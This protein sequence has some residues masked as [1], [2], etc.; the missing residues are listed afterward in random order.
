MS[1]AMDRLKLIAEIRQRPVLWDFQSIEHKSRE[2]A[3]EM[4]RDVAQIMGTDVDECKRKW[5][6]LRDA[7]RAEVKRIELRIERDLLKGSYDTNAEYSSKWA[8]F[9]AMKFIED[10]K[11]P[12]RSRVNEN[13]N[14][15]SNDNYNDDNDSDQFA[16]FHNVESIKLE[17]DAEM[18]TDVY[19]L[20]DED[21]DNKTQMYS[22]QLL[23]EA[24]QIQRNKS[25][26]SIPGQNS[27]QKQ[28]Q[29][30]KDRPTS[31]H[32]KCTKRS[33]DQVHFLEDLEKEEQ[34]LMK[35]TRLDITRTND[36]GHVG[37]SDYNFLV[38]FLPQ[39]KKMSDLQNL[40]FRAKITDVVLNIM[41]QSMA[42]VTISVS[43]S[44]NNHS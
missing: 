32:C 42:N 5:K 31:T 37:D 3:P 36:L 2:Y 30:Q 10:S 14:L 18:D 43:S 11:R 20:D 39:M 4:W 7:Y 29:A 41:S 27:P 28:N 40:Q 24:E 38:S 23:R 22:E 19:L 34:N 35:S 9:E 25:P 13:P 26:Q 8:F 44:H 16:Q 15:S 33:Y 12:R 17:P 21:D 6:N 1:N